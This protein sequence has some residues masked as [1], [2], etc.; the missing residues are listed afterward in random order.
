MAIGSGTVAV[1]GQLTLPLLAQA[2]PS[3]AENAPDVGTFVW[4]AGLVILMTQ[5][6]ALVWRRQHVGTVT[7]TVVAAVPIGAALGMGPALGLT[8]MAT[9]I[10]VYTLAMSRPLQRAWP[11]LTV[12]FFTVTAGH[13]VA[14]LN[15]QVP[16][17]QAVGAALLQGASLI[18]VPLIVATLVATRRESR[19]AREDQAR[20]LEREHEALVQS[21]IA[22]ERTSM[23]RELHDIAAHHLTGIAIMSAAIS[24]QIDTDPAAAKEAVEELRHQSTAVLRDLRSLVGLLRD[25]DASADDDPAGIRVE[26]LTG[27]PD[28]VSVV[29]EGGRD[30]AVTVLDSPDGQ[31]LGWSI[32]PL[33]QLATYRMV[34]EALANAGRHAEGARCEI[35]IDDRDPAALVV[36]V[37]NSPAARATNAPDRSGFG[38]VGMQERAELTGS[39]LEH[40]FTT[41]GGWTASLR[42]ASCAGPASRTRSPCSCSPPL[43]STST[44]SALWRLARRGSC[45]RTLS[46]KNWWPRS[47]PWPP[48]MARSTVLSPNGC[49]ARWSPAGASRLSRQRGP[50]TC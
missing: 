15:T 48:A 29:I 22:R 35:Q 42:P 31:P 45:S 8:S 5:S 6:I 13:L 11:L 16:V 2:D 38:L 47:A 24:G 37:R 30:V 41:D 14:G 9:L 25:N 33:A 23:A 17:G 10:A 43:T 21:A 49:C 36:T 39:H 46:Q 3:V 1:L 4:W 12:V 32:G 20:A 50:Q 18:G 44:C 40:G 28:L 7:A 19:S 34:Q 26:S 27:I